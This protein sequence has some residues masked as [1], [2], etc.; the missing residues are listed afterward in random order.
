LAL[1]HE[2]LSQQIDQRGPRKTAFSAVFLF[3]K[4]KR[5]LNL[6][7][8]I[9]I[10]RN[11][12][13]ISLEIGRDRRVLSFAGEAKPFP[14]FE[15]CRFGRCHGDHSS[16]WA[17][18]GRRVQSKRTSERRI[19]G[20]VNGI[21]RSPRPGNEILTRLLRNL[22]YAMASVTGGRFARP[23]DMEPISV[24]RSP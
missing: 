20:A 13:K 8:S 17:A 9:S 22:V 15:V 7:Y 16:S 5:G 14:A 4:P 1:R 23:P 3:A 11:N 6:A 10:Y 24:G 12:R 2:V 21:M 19:S 18:F